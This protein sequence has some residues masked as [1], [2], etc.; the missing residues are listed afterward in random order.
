[1]T[2]PDF[3]PGPPGP[4][5]PPGPFPPLPPSGPPFPHSGPPFPQSPAPVAAVAPAAR[6]RRGLGLMALAVAAL[7][8]LVAVVASV[9][10][11]RAGNDAAE[12]RELAS[13][14]GAQRGPAPTVPTEAAPPPAEPP[15][16]GG[17]ADPATDPGDPNATGEPRL[18][19]RTTYE[20]KYQREPLTVSSECNY[21]MYVDVDE[22]RADVPSTG[23]DVA[24]TGGCGVADPPTLRLGEG[25]AGTVAGSRMSTPADCA[26]KIRQ[27]PIGSDVSVPARQGVVLCINTSYAAARERGDQWRI[28]R[29]EIVSAEDGTARI[30]AYAWNVT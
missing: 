13:A 9:V 28:A 17:P 3:P 7:S 15:P 6:P 14:L 8:L 22:P 2:A 21:S 18:D 25:V 24:F 10:A 12:A 5:V 27:A 1:V 23:W 16:A 20:V 29:L 26:E 19:E 4:A 30:E 11:V